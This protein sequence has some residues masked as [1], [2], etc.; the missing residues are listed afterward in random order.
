MNRSVLL[1][2]LAATVIVSAIACLSLI[3]LLI[4]Q[5]ALRQVLELRLEDTEREI[6]VLY[7]GQA[8]QRLVAPINPEFLV[9]C[10]S[11]SVFFVSGEDS[12]KVTS[13]E[14]NEQLQPHVQ[15]E[16]VVWNRDSVVWLTLL[17][18][19]QTTEIGRYE[20]GP[21]TFNVFRDTQ[22]SWE[23]SNVLMETRYGPGEDAD[24]Q[25]ILMFECDD[26]A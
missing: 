3:A 4:H 11:A 2:A 19:K 25:L 18:T 1:G 20:G 26:E 14:L 5:A 17:G 15:L 21:N 7:R 12:R 23:K 6:E 10:S 8:I 24:P 22:G 9:T 16:A 13:I